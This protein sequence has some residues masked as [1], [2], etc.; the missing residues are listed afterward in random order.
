MVCSVCELVFQNYL[1]SLPCL[2]PCLEPSSALCSRRTLRMECIA[3]SSWWLFGWWTSRRWEERKIGASSSLCSLSASALHP[4]QGQH[5]SLTTAHSG[6]FLFPGSRAHGLLT[7]LLPSLA[8][9]GQGWQWLSVVASSYTTH[10]Q[11]LLATGLYTVCS[12]ALSHLTWIWFLA[13][14]LICKTSLLATTIMEVMGYPKC[15][16]QIFKNNKT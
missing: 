10:Q 14:R 7:T 16:T 1:P 4:W 13:R 11:P 5:P 8:L 2:L 6:S 3:W 15:Q 12:S 9:P